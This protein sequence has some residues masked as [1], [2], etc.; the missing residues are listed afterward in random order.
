MEQKLTYRE[1]SLKEELLADFKANFPEGSTI[2]YSVFGWFIE[3][4]A[5]LEAEVFKPN[6]LKFIMEDE[7]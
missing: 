6:S 4:I 3:R 1:K 7:K 5:V 2:D